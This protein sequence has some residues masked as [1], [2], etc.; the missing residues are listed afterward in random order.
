MELIL[1]ITKR[2]LLQNKKRTLLTILTIALSVGMMTAVLCGCLSALLFLREKET[3]YNGTYAYSIELTAP[4]QAQTLLQEDSVTDVALLDFVGNAFYDE[5]S[6]RSMLAIAAINP[7]F[8]DC[9]QLNDFIIAG[10]IPKN[11]RELM[12]SETFL[13]RNGLSLTVGDTFSFTL[14]TRVWDE[15]D[16]NLYGLVSYM[17]ERE[18]FHAVEK[19]TYTIVGIIAD[20]PDSKTAH[21]F[22]AYTGIGDSCTDLTAYVTCADI[23]KEVYTQASE[24]ADAVNGTVSDFHSDLLMYYGVTQ[25]KGSLKIMAAV[26]VLILLLMAAGSAM[27]SN[28]LSISLQERIRQ[29]GMLASVGATGRQ[30]RASVHMEAALL[31][32][33]G[34]PAGLL[35]GYGLSAATLSIIRH[36][37]AETFCLETL[38]LQTVMSADICLLGVLTGILSL[39]S[40]CRKPAKEAARVSIISALRQ[41]A[42][43]RPGHVRRGRFCD[44]LFGVCGSLAAKNIRRNPKR[45]RAITGSIILS[46]VLGLSLYS[47]SD[48]MLLQASMEMKADGSPYTD[49][50]TG[51][52]YR[53]LQR[54]VSTV[55]KTGN[56][57]DMSY[58]I[59]RYMTCT[60]T[61]AQ[62]N[63][64]MSGYVSDDQEA[65]L[66][67]VG[68]D[69]E[70]FLAFCEENGIDGSAYEKDP[71]QAILLNH[72]IGS[73]APSSKRSIAGSPLQLESGCE[74]TMLCE[75]DDSTRKVTIGAVIDDPAA[76][77]QAQF[78]QNLV[79]LVL[80]IS[81]FD[82]TLTDDTYVSLSVWT[83]QHREVAQTLS[84]V[85]FFQT[86]D[87]AQQTANYRQICMLLRLMIGIFTILMTC[88]IALNICNTIMNT[89]QVRKTEFAVLRSIGMTSGALKKMLLLEAALYGTRALIIALPICLIIHGMLYSMISTSMTPFVFYIHLPA[90]GIAILIVALIV[91]S[92]MLFSLKNTAKLDLVSQLK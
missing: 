78:V 65:E 11:D 58:S 66:Y 16:A 3:A 30:K 77:T 49:V 67:A 90:Y 69:T 50:F 46:V 43:Y 80:P 53:D 73:Y 68:M 4:A 5:P 70:H 6:N 84:D 82:W 56:A 26:T 83:P 75:D 79:V 34:I 9:F 7:S 41:T 27:I 8:I 47:F 55:T 10:R 62:I 32:C 44:L 31:G 22:N 25:G 85:G 64:S 81:Y 59:A 60:L 45:F 36:M 28:V 89:L 52:P 51:V 88:I 42:V 13:D 24:Q 20:T 33:I 48:F 29:L 14:G 15:I 61:E 18:S 40:A 91:L 76:G 39:M 21:Y 35:A 17:G 23:S 38:Q 71:T 37:F 2:N 54:A 87:V 92:A 57:T 86:V 1:T 72:A 63:P 19:N 12:L 74:L